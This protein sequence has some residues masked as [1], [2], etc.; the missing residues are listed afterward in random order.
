MVHRS[1]DI[2]HFIVF[3]VLLGMWSYQYYQI[4]YIYH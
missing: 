3:F 4:Y 2:T 1:F